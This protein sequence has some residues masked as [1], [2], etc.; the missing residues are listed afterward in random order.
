MWFGELEF[1]GVS[2][3]PMVWAA[4]ASTYVSEPAMVRMPWTMY[5]WPGLPRLWYGGL[6]SGLALAVGSALLLNALLLATFVWVELLSPGWLRAAWLAIGTLW[7]GA[8]GVSAW[9]G[10]GGIRRA[11]T[12]E[13]M[14]REALHEYL[15][16]SWFESERILRR[17]LARHP[18]DV[19]ARLMLATLLRHAARAAEA[20]EELA[21]LERLEDA[22][23][24]AVEIAAERAWLERNAGDRRTDPDS[25]TDTSYP[26][27][28]ARA[29]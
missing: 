16:G 12:A 3:S 22:G 9:M 26:T 21:R 5:L 20:A 11:E 29:A 19:E 8:A 23:R 17:L 25:N 2:M 15:K 7:I 28:P 10:R 6:W 13:A 4:G 14:F 27:A 1:R 24:W 18:R